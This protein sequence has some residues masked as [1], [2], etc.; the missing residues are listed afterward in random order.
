MVFAGCCLA[1]V[2]IVFLFMIETKDRTLEEIDT[3]YMLHV[4]PIGSAKW[5]ASKAHHNGSATTSHYEDQQI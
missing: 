3:M 1:L 2:F 5:D 4:N